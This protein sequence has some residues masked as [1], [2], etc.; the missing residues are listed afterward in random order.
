MGNLQDVR[1]TTLYRE[2][3]RKVGRFWYRFPEGE[4]GADVFGRTKDWW[5]TVR[6][7]PF[8]R[9]RRVLPLTPMHG[10][11]YTSVT[12]AVC[13]RWLSLY[14]SPDTE[15]M[16][17]WRNSTLLVVT[18]GLTM[19]LVLMQLY[20]WSPTTFHS[21]WNANNCD[22][23]VLDRDTSH[24][25]NYVINAT[26]SDP[27]RS[28]IDVAITLKP[29]EGRK[30]SLVFSSNVPPSECDDPALEGYLEIP[31]PR[32]HQLSEVKKMIAG[33]FGEKHGFQEEDILTVCGHG[34]FGTFAPTDGAHGG[35]TAPGGHLWS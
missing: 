2:A 26:L 4:S 23:V 7:V 19:R 21:L 29:S 12:V 1:H 32:M 17:K 14:G 8:T 20:D 6:D 28:S 9:L 3:Q 10:Y 35:S 22:F 27:I 31:K 24:H 33:Q 16:E 13:M 5:A 30:S 25:R 15:M 11:S 34:P 18:H